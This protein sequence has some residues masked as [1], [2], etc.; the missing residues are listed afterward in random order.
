M[1]PTPVGDLIFMTH[2]TDNVYIYYDGRFNDLHL[3][4]QHTLRVPEDRKNY[5]LPVIP[6][7]FGYSA[8][9]QVTRT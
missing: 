2:Y 5:P 1:T 3:R 7:G 6:L 4:L 9:K 8:E